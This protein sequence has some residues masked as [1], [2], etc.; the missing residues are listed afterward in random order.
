[1]KPIPALEYEVSFEAKQNDGARHD[2]EERYRTLFELAP[3][4]VYCCDVSG[5]IVDYN[6]RA[7]ELWAA[8]R[9][10]E[11]PM[12]AFVAHSSCT[13]QTAVSCHTSNALWA[14]C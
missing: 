2:N 9:N 4:A 1:M 11:I 8:S 5:V 3:V 6:N 12:S 10:S 14:M 7:A 13:G